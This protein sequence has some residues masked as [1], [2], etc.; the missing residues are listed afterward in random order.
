DAIAALRQP[1]AFFIGNEY[2]FMPEKM[3][4][5]EGLGV[6]LLVTQTAHPGVH[7]AYRERLG[8]TVAG[9]PNTGQDPQVF[10]PKTPVPQRPIDLGLRSADGSWYLGHRERQDMAEYFTANAA[11]L[12]L[13]VDISLDPNERFAER[14]WAGFLNQCRGQLGTEAGGDYFELTDATRQ[15]VNAFQEDHPHA[16]FEEIRRRF[17]DGYAHPI[18]LRIMSGR[19]VEAAGTTS[20]QTRFEGH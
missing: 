2:K 10:R 11:R 5:G 6:S 15:A 19:H 8:C 18:P 9:I 4:F 1:K 12:G 17:F 7:Q 3:A 14:E 13:T 16:A 20:V